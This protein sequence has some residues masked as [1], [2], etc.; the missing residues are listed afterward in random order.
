[1]NEDAKSHPKK[2]MH[3]KPLAKVAHMVGWQRQQAA[4]EEW[5]G[6]PGEGADDQDPSRCQGHPLFLPMIPQAEVETSELGG[7]EEPTRLGRC[8]E[9]EEDAK[10]AED[11]QKMRSPGWAAPTWLALIEVTALPWR[12]RGLG[13]QDVEVPGLAHF[14]QAARRVAHTAAG[15]GAALP[16]GRVALD[17]DGIF[18]AVWRELDFAAG[19]G[20]IRF[21]IYE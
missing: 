16:G 21:L 9:D 18:G 19:L 8:L 20:A 3:P 14:A 10:D 5:V 17:Q 7:Q 2:R 6:V 13:H 1:M 11:A 4:S 15:Q 12:P